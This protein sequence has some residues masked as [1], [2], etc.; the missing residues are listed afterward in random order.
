MIKSRIE[1][2]DHPVPFAVEVKYAKKMTIW[3]EEN[4]KV[5][6]IEKNNQMSIHVECVI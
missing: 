5:A 3:L 1:E 6:V 2:I 4:L